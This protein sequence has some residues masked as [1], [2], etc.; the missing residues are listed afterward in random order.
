MKVS[1]VAVSKSPAASLT[2]NNSTLAAKTLCFDT[3]FNTLDN[4]ETVQNI[5]EKLGKNDNQ[6]MCR[7]QEL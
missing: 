1:A 4:S 2:C 3:L 6:V 7:E 5:F